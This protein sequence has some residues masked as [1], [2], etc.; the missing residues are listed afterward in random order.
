MADGSVY[1]I[2]R[3]ELLARTE[4]TLLV[5]FTDTD[6]FAVLDLMLVT[7]IEVDDRRNGKKRRKAG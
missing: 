5:A 2:A 6:S 7:A 3:P 4:R 1:G